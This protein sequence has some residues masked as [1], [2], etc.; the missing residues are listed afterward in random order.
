[1]ENEV[2]V[3]CW[4][5]SRSRYCDT[6]PKNSQEILVPLNENFDKDFNGEGYNVKGSVLLMYKCFILSY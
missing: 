2:S 1:M 6:F 3:K 5:L 4:A